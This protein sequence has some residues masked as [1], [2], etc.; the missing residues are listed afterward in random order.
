MSPNR[1]VHRRGVLLYVDPYP[2][3]ARAVLRALPGLRV[4]ICGSL[5]EARERCAQPGVDAI[6]TRD[7]LGPRTGW[8]LL[9]SISL[10]RAIVGRS[11]SQGAESLQ[12]RGLE[13]PFLGREL[14]R[15]A[16]ELIGRDADGA[17]DH[18]L[19]GGRRVA[20]ELEDV[21]FAA[22]ELGRDFGLREA[23]V[24]S[25]AVS[26]MTDDREELA[27][28]LRVT[29]HTLQ[30]YATRVRRLT[31]RSIES[32]AKVILRE[33]YLRDRRDVA[34]ASGSYPSVTKRAAKSA[35]L[36]DTLAQ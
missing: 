28:R 36:R 12:C 11:V 16:H 2:A 14:R 8:S 4:E 29:A 21:L 5:E 35:S 25:I 3:G 24:H 9:A 17:I 32:W 13:A 34:P 18:R 1:D 19:H 22:L 27:A 20:P 6:V 15:L 10:S 7:Q 26:T 23:E 31:D 33:V 30:S